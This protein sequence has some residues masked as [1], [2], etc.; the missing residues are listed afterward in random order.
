MECESLKLEVLA[1][2]EGG[3][4]VFWVVLVGHHLEIFEV[5]DDC[6]ALL[7]SGRWTWSRDFY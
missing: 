4:T 3:D 5:L 6:K 1:P 2:T 7:V